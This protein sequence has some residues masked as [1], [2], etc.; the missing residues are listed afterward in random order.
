MEEK[1]NENTSTAKETANNK[2]KAKLK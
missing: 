2:K 1:K